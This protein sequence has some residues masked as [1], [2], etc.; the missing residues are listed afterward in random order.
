L[1]DEDGHPLPRPREQDAVSVQQVPLAVRLVDVGP[2]VTAE[3][4]VLPAPSTS[5]RSASHVTQA[6]STPSRPWIWNSVA[7][8]V[9]RIPA[10]ANVDGVRPQPHGL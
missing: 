7:E 6:Q 4:V 10:H 1:R 9:D 5:R 2:Y 8:P 3:G